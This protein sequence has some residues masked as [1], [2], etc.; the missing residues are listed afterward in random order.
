MATP[1]Y[2]LLERQLDTTL[3]LIISLSSVLTEVEVTLILVHLDQAGIIL[4]QI[5]AE[6]NRS[7]SN[8]HGKIYLTGDIQLMQFLM[9]SATHHSNN[10][11]A[12]RG[13]ASPQNID[14]SSSNSSGN[15]NPF[16]PSTSRDDVRRHSDR[17]LVPHE[18]PTTPSNMDTRGSRRLRRTRNMLAPPNNM[19]SDSDDYSY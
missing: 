1:I 9:F 3:E 18:A 19:R 12:H 5:V 17:Q 4:G 13:T 2:P 11:P 15:H 7:T 16:H 14:S 8:D 6:R 10:P